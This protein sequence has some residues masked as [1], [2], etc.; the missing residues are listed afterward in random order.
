[1]KRPRK[2]GFMVRRPAGF[3]RQRTP[4]F[5]RHVQAHAAVIDNEAWYGDGPPSLGKSFTA[6]DTAKRHALVIGLLYQA[7]KKAAKF[8]DTE[9]HAAYGDLAD[10][11][12]YCKPKAR[13]G[14]L[15]CPQ[16][17]RA[18]QKAKVSAQNTLITDLTLDRTD[19]SLVFVS[20]VPEGMT[21]NPGKFSNIEIVKANRWL[22]DALKPVG[23]DRPIMGSADLGWETRRG[24]Q[25]IQL[26]WHLALWT[27]DPEQ[28]EA[29]LKK[30]FRR[31]QK[32]ERPVDVRETRD[33][34]FLPY[35]NKAIKLPD[36]LRSNRKN[37]PELLLVLDRTEPL[38]LLVMSKLRLSAQLGTL[39]IKRAARSTNKSKK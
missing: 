20:V 12:Y 18:F 2:S 21:Y 22:K 9:L 1:M 26:H 16:C 36:L 27:N 5:Q 17:A 29:K 31:T 30:I 25:Y 39:A 34:G 19:K 6:A 15:A 11:L 24:G 10:K 33:L 14:S 7:A 37:L 13:C 35:Q 28:L 23:M 38:D 32:Y 3:S 4:T 8:K